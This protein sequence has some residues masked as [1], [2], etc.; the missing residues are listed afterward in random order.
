MSAQVQTK[1]S[2]LQKQL[3]PHIDRKA[4]PI[5]NEE[6][7]KFWA[8]SRHLPE[9]DQSYVK[10]L[11]YAAKHDQENALQW[12]N[13]ALTYDDSTIAMNYLAYLGRSAQNYLHRIETLRLEKFYGVPTIRRVARNACFGVGD[14]RGVKVYSRKLAALRDGE[15]RK[16]I[17]DEGDYMCNIIDNFKRA[18]SFSS[19]DIEELNKLAEGIA[20]QHG[21][22]CYE[23][24][25]FIGGEGDNAYILGANT[26]D[27]DLITD[28]NIELACA[29]TD[30]KYIGK[31]VTSWFRSTM[32]EEAAN[33]R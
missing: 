24:N 30:E 32:Y 4:V 29:M 5:D 21:V 7:E 11:A 27:I 10:A 19:N 26:D 13:S 12:F 17:L 9:P 18:T 28:M 15:D 22:A 25:Y 3:F 31:P 16:K 33:E 2:Q 8:E 6:F 23:V 14:C 20:N 1:I